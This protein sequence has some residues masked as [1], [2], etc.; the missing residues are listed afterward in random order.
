MEAF[1]SPVG[2][3]THEGGIL[4]K[5]FTRLINPKKPAAAVGH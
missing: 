2:V 3:W 1:F 4:E 5:F